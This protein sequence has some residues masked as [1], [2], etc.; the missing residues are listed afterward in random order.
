MRLMTKLHTHAPH[1]RHPYAALEREMEGGIAR[2]IR[3]ESNALTL[4]RAYAP[5]RKRAWKAAPPMPGEEKA[6]SSRGLR[7]NAETAG[8]ERR[9]DFDLAETGG[10]GAAFQTF[11][12]RPGGVLLGSRL[13][14]EEEGRVKAKRKE[15]WSVRVSPFVCG[16][17]GEAPEDGSGFRA[18]KMLGNRRQDED[19]CGG[20]IA[21]GL[22]LDL[23]QAASGKLG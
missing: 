16:V 20:R 9:L 1:R 17:G 3:I 5:A 4:R 12:Q 2:S 15:T 7:G 11:L 23:M 8:E 18:P 21:I 6:G 10:K 19:D 14:D 22:C 13:D